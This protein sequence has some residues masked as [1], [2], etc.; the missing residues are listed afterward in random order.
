MFLLR[1]NRR[2]GAHRL[3][4]LGEESL[5]VPPATILSPQRIAIG[6]RVLVL[7]DVTFSVVDE[8]R[9][10]RHEPSLS[11]GDGTLVARRV[12]FSCVGR[13]EIGADVLIGHGV[14]IS[15]SFHEYAD[16][17][18]P[19]IMQPMAPAKTVRIKDG[20]S[21]GPG[22]AILSGSTVG[23]G[24]YVAANAVVAG[25]VP[26]H[27]VAAGNPAEIIRRW[28]GSRGGW[29]DTD[30]PRWRDLLTSLTPSV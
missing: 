26:D 7:E 20:A 13:I 21:I 27:A 19:V 17:D 29:V 6:A 8:H 18:R 16:R 22:A 15:D 3:S 11:I 23:K 9:G 14:L 25:E 4:A 5:V 2:S 1:K 30:E 24:A 10:R 28:D 12:W